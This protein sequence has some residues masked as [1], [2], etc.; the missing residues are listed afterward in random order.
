MNSK[1][2][3][4]LQIEFKSIRPQVLRHRAC[5]WSA[6]HRPRLPG[7]VLSRAGPLHGGT[8]SHDLGRMDRWFP[9]LAS[10]P[11]FNRSP[12]RTNRTVSTAMKSAAARRA[13]GG[14]RPEATLV[15]QCAGAAKPAIGGTPSK[16]ALF[17]ETG[18]DAGAVRDTDK[19]E[20]HARTHSAP[21]SS[22]AAIQSKLANIETDSRVRLPFG[23]Y[24]VD[25]ASSH[26]LVSK[27]K[28][29]MSKY[30]YCTAKLQTAH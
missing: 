5:L 11:G 12:V 29:C 25:P 19:C 8:L 7:T 20:T 1:C 27:I 6:A 10:S 22:D 3:S 13:Y 26:M 4:V 18:P 2:E 15:Q 30:K 14:H 23:S 21:H 24:L 28:P 17:A 16:R 9:T